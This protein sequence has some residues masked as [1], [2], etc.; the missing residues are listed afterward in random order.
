M[1][2]RHQRN[3][4]AQKDWRLSRDNSSCACIILCS[5]CGLA[6]IPR[7]PATVWKPK[8]RSLFCSRK[9]LPANTNA[10]I[11]YIAIPSQFITQSDMRPN[12]INSE[13]DPKCRVKKNANRRFYL[14]FVIFL[15]AAQNRSPG[16]KSRAIKF[17]LNTKQLV[18]L[19]KT[20]RP[21]QR[22]SFDLASISRHRKISYKAIFGLTRPM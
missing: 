6:R 5:S 4:V 15:L 7:S 22:S 3:T 21:R 16:V 12:G 1:L 20:I 13:S 19:R 18:I 11:K 14:I 8:T 17:L 2:L 9:K 10:F